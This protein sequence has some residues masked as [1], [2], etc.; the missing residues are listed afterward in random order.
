MS[1]GSVANPS[2]FDTSEPGVPMADAGRVR[3]PMFPLHTAAKVVIGV[4]FVLV[5]DGVLLAAFG[6]TSFLGFGPNS[7]ACVEAPWAVAHVNAAGNPLGGLRPG[8]STDPGTF[9]VCVNQ[10][11]IAQT[12]LSDLT[13]VPIELLYVG[14]AVLVVQLARTTAREGAFTLRTA[15]Q[16]RRLA[17][18]LLI[19]ELVAGGVQATATLSL[20]DSMTT[21]RTSPIAVAE[22]WPFPWLALFVSLGLLAFARIVR[23]GVTMR[24]ENEATI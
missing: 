7:F 23:L 17:W 6:V 20:F 12:L 1:M 16:L 14:L 9:H 13:T 11:G 3:N 5:V 24:E 15:G 10:P 8:I 4:A 2:I 22:F 21:Y 19:G 18:A